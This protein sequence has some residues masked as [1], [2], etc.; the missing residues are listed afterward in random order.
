L[1]SSVIQIT[2]SRLLIKLT[3]P[4]MAMST[5]R[6]CTKPCSKANFGGC[7][8]EGSMK[9]ALTFIRPLALDFF[10]RRC[11]CHMRPRVVPANYRRQM[12][13]TRS[14]RVFG[15]FPTGWAPQ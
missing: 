14:L 9:P 13:A 1:W 11:E 7:H 2:P 15:I 6:K 5:I 3:D 10:A 12:I 8:P 4:E